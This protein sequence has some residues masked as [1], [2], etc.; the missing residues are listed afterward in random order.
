MLKRLL[1][2]MA[3]AMAS[4]ASAFAQG[5]CQSGQIFGNSSGAAGQCTTSSVSAILDRAFGSTRGSIIERGSSGWAIVGPGATSG[6]PWVSN[7]AGADPSYQALSISG[8]GL[9]GFGTGVVT[10]LGV[11]VGTA[12]AFVVNGGALGVPSS[13]TLTNA[14][15]LPVSTGITGFGTGV[16]TA[17]GVNVGSAGAVV[18]NGGAL[19]T[20][21]SGTL[22]NATGLP[23]STGVT[24]NLPTGNLN[25]GTGATSATFWRGDGT[26]GTPLGSSQPQGRLTLATGTPVMTAS[27]TS[28]T[29]LFY[30]CYRG[31]NLVP[32]YNGT[33]DVALTI[34]SCEVSTAMQPSGTGVLNAN[35]V[36]DV[37]AINVTNALNICVATNGS[38][39]GWASDTGG[40]NTARGTGYSQLDTTTRPY[41]TNK[42][43]ITHCYTNTTDQGSIS[44]NRA[45]YLG[46]VLTDAASA[47]EVS[48]TFGSNAAGGG[49]ARFGVFNEYNRV[50]VKTQ[51]LNSDTNWTYA[52]ANTWRAA[53]SSATYRVTA[54][55]GVNDEGV[56]I[57]YKGICDSGAAGT[58]ITTGV[59]LDST[60]A[61]TGDTAWTNTTSVV[62]MPALFAGVPGIGLHFFSAIELNSTTTASTCFGN[63]SNA[64]SSLVGDLRL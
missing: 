21:S 13:G 40:S 60:T 54:V 6:V 4:V 12:G 62:P 51:V 30:D 32:V 3:L 33:A 49:A 39:G 63:Q 11:N 15:G 58:N 2:A 18:V 45:T 22:T 10:A 28:Q 57:T 59:G 17:L 36:F 47:G 20:P 9:T 43:A 37:W 44:A 23:L 50:Q 35:G 8:S 42:N 14:T 52:V 16:A 1:F 56:Q 19:G 5:Q 46:T 34:T 24:G 26:W 61:N 27:N 55:F 53:D 29:N 38:G 41:L 25:S 64:I 7:G 31:G 48:Y